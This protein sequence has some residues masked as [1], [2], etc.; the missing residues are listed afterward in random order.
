MLRLTNYKAIIAILLNLISYDIIRLLLI[1]LILDYY[2]GSSASPFISGL[3]IKLFT[4]FL[5]SLGIAL[6]RL[7]L[8]LI[9]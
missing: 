2:S 9:G 6:I 1:V 4:Y 5:F 3:N 7:Y 8:V